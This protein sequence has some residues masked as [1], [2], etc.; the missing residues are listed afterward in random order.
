MLLEQAAGNT[1]SVL[2]SGPVLRIGP[3]TASLGYAPVKGRRPVATSTM[4]H[5][6]SVLVPS[7]V[8]SYV[9]LTRSPAASVPTTCTR[10][11]D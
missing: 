10:G 2:S 9:S 11:A 5:S 7:L 6:M 8:L 4:S 3:N 1:A